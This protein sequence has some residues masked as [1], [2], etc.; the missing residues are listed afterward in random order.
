MPEL[1][2]FDQFLKALD[3]R[4][5]EELYYR[6]MVDM[7]AAEGPRTVLDYGCGKGQLTEELA[8]RGIQAIGYDPD[9]ASIARCLQHSSQAEY[10][11]RDMLET[12]RSDGARFDTVVCGRVLCTIADDSEFNNVLADL[13][14]LVA[15]SGTVLVSVCNPFHLETVST[16]LGEKHLPG[17]YRYEETFVYDKTV[18]VNGNRRREVHRSFSTCRRALPMLASA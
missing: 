12:L 15:E 16:E 13:R 18:G 8:H 10:G 7:V 1:A 9:L 3:P 17:G 5:L 2:G 14:G 11:G 4:G 6:P